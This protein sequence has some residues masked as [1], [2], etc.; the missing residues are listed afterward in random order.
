MKIPKYVDTFFLL[1][2]KINR[3][4][5]YALFVYGTNIAVE[6]DTYIFNW[7]RSAIHIHQTEVTVIHLEVTDEFLFHENE[8]NIIILGN[9]TTPPTT[10]AK[11]PSVLCVTI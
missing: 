11:I 5:I 1:E 6:F 8:T 2:T 4:K 3:W 7:F 10:Q 9:E